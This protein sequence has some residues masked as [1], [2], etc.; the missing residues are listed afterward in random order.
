MTSVTIRP[1]RVD[2]APL[3]ACLLGDLG[4][5]TMAASAAE[6]LRLLAGTGSDPVFLALADDGASGLLALHVT[7]MLHL[8]APIARITVLVISEG[9]R[10]RG[11]GTRLI[12]TAIR[13]AE[14]EGCASLELT[15]GLARKEAHAFYAA[16]GFTNTSL[17]FQCKVEAGD[18]SKLRRR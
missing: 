3:V 18:G 9:A 14:S 17:K 10:G 12:E 7:R 8:E 4:S 2:D 1:A 6:R 13:H 5:P 11:I 15:S 16:K